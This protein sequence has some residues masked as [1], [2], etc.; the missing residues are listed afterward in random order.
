[1]GRGRGL[2]G[3]VSVIGLF[4][5]SAPLTPLMPGPPVIV[6]PLRDNSC[7][8]SDEEVRMKEEEEEE[9]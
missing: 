3:G 5:Q 1:M 9:D 7:F 6:V 8:P 2:R 4:S